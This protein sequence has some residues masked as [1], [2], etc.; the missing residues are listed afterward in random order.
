MVKPPLA[1]HVKLLLYL[2]VS[3][4]TRWDDLLSWLWLALF[5]NLPNMLD[6][7][8]KRPRSSWKSWATRLAIRFISEQNPVQVYLTLHKSSISPTPAEGTSVGGKQIGQQGFYTTGRCEK[9]FHYC[10]CFGRDWK[11]GK[12]PEPSRVEGELASESTCMDVGLHMSWP[13]RKEP[14]PCVLL[15]QLCL[16]PS[17]LRGLASKDHQHGAQTAYNADITRQRK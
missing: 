3:E 14:C 10:F 8:V 15:L 16:F 11:M 12:G 4:C 5:R 17:L 2:T 9:P 7:I 1:F 13:G 6:V